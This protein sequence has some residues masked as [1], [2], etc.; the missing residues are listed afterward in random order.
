MSPLDTNRRLA[1]L[2]GWTSISHAGFELR[3]LPPDAQR[4]GLHEGRI[5]DWTGAWCACGPLMVEYLQR[6]AQRPYRAT[7]GAVG[8]MAIM[9]D[10]I[11]AGG[12]DEAARRAIVD[13]M[14]EVLEAGG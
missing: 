7:A 3:G 4:W 9:R 10:R 11:A 1:E 5:P 13:A 12:G 14:I 8:L 2:L 6:I